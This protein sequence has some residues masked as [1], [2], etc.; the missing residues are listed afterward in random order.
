MFC[1]RATNRRATMA[2]RTHRV[3][4][5]TGAFAFAVLLAAPAWSAD[6]GDTSGPGGTDVP[7]RCGDRVTTATSLD[8]GD[9]VL[10][11]VCPG[12]GLLI[13]PFIGADVTINGTLRGSGQGC[14]IR[15][16]VT[17]H[18]TVAVGRIS[19]FGH[20]FCGEDVNAALSRL[21]IVD[22][23][24]GGV[25]ITESGASIE[26]S[27]IAR[28]GGPGMVLNGHVDAFANQVVDNAGPGIIASTD[29][30]EGPGGDIA[31]NTIQRN[32]GD[33]VVVDCQSCRFERNSIRN[34]QGVGIRD[35]SAQNDQGD[36]EFVL[37]VCAGNALGDSDPPG[38]C[39]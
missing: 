25:R 31:R 28:N 38:L 24:L 26:R 6:C 11:T 22:N 8:A 37:N 33:G 39:R 2:M 7:C 32:A 18:F 34:N 29:L 10:S 30:G 17:G 20:G 23:A 36:N 1:H 5:S 15:A 21:Q 3:L 35:I 27:L 12:D 14:G 13:G 4:L 19:G 9:P 16:E